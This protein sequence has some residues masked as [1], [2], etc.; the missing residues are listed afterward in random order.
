MLKN[1]LK[2]ALRALIRNKGFS[3]INILGLAVGMSCSILIMLWVNHELTFD[4]FHAKGD[5]IVRVVRLDAENP[6]DG[7]ARTGA[8][9]GPALQQDYPEVESSVRFRYYGRTL[10]SAGDKRFFDDEGLYADP[11]FFDIFSFELLAGDARTALIEPT[12]IVLTQSLARKH[13]GEKNPVGEFMTLDKE[14]RRI[15][16][17]VQ[18]VP[19]NSHFSFSFLVPF[20]SYS[21][22][23]LDEWDVSNFHVY[24]LLRSKD[25]IKPLEAKMPEFVTR[26]LDAE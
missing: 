4:R 16:G 14:N 21:L 8:P 18:D 2:V 26:H 13:F 7:I 22:W 1:Y 10:M 9:W 20:S 15:T 24:L 3:L 23:D 25:D 5:R 11:T 17:V 6:S 19:E 12:S